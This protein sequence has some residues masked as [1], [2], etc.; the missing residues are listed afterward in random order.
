MIGRAI[1]SPNHFREKA[2]KRIKT[3]NLKKIKKYIDKYIKD[4]IITV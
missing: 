3:A 1:C 2:P 4:D